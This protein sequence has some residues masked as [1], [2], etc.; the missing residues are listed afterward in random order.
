MEKDLPVKALQTTFRIIDLLS[1][2]NTMSFS[3]IAEQLDQPN[4]TV[5]DHL[6]SLRELQ[7]ITKDENQYQIGFEFLL[8]GDRRRRRDEL[9]VKGRSVVDEIVE[10]TGEHTSLFIEENGRGRT[11][12]TKQGENS[13]NFNV[14]DG[15]Q[16][17]LPFTAS[18]KAILSTLQRSQVEELLDQQGLLQDS[19]TD[20]IT[21][22]EFYDELDLTSERGFA[23]DD[24]IAFK[25][26][27]GIAVPIIDK[28]NQVQG[29]VGIYGPVSRLERNHDQDELVR[30]LK[31]K[32]NMIE[33]D[34]NYDNSSQH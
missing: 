33:L 26:M 18:G 3:E 20:S 1:K 22:S 7:Y 5:Y 30:I 24:Q 11:I 4:S 27:R 16:S 15:E 19:T 9:F 32:K 2:H 28:D 12:Y 23:L 29:A 13:I 31:N 25:G 14:Y 6:Q 34:L 10:I 17:H 8:I 21:R